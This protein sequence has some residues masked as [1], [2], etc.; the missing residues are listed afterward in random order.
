MHHEVPVPVECFNLQLTAEAV[1]R[2]QMK[3]ENVVETLSIAFLTVCD[4]FGP[5]IYSKKK[6]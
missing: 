1:D 5:N 6:I 2:G 3:I 4:R